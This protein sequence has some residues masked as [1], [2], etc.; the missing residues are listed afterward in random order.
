MMATS[1]PAGFVGRQSEL[2][3][4]AERLAAAALGHPQVV[5]VEGEIGGG[6]STLL[7]RFLGSLANEVVLEVAGDEAETLLSYGIV[8]QLQPG[9]PTEPGTDPMAVG[10]RLLDL[11]DRRQ[12]GGQVVVLVIDDL[13]WVDR[14]SSRAVLAAAGRQGTGGRGDAGGRAH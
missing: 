9:V 14:P 10:A 1:S 7:A 13:Q 5:Y 6:K 11:L 3:I 2:G 12:A 8:D 4:L